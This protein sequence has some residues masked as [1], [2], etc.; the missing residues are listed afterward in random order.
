MLLG[1]GGGVDPMMLRDQP[2]A[3]ALSE[4]QEILHLAAASSSSL[5]RVTAGTYVRLRQIL[6]ET[7]HSRSLPGFLRQCLTIERFRDFIHLY[8][9]EPARRAEFLES[10]FRSAPVTQY[11]RARD[12]FS[13]WEL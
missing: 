6:L 12:V 8:D 1:T 4:L 7:D 10:A 13:D 11:R 2:V 3:E 5:P 9:P